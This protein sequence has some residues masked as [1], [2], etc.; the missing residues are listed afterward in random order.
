ARPPLSTEQILHPDQY[1]AEEAPIEIVPPDLSCVL[2]PRYRRLDRNHAGEFLITQWASA[3][4]MDGPRTGAG[5]GGD[6]YEIWLD[7]ETQRTV[8]V[9][10]TTWDAKED[11]AEFLD[12]A[13]S[14]FTRRHEGCAMEL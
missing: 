13:A 6:V 12:T 9:W 1:L 8:L 4:A 11:A 7:T 14:G 5:W 2:G 10:W 3:R